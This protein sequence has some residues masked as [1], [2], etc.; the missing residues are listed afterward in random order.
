[1]GSGVSHYNVSL[2][3]GGQSHN[4]TVSINHNLR[5][6]N[7]SGAS[8]SPSAYSPSTLVVVALSSLARISGGKVSHLCQSVN[9]KPVPFFLFF[10]L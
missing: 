7:R 6:V 10:P 5:Q 3:V 1:M 8:R 4:Y 2:I 9:Q